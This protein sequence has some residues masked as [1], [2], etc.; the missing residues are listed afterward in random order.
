MFTTPK[1]AIKLDLY[2][3]RLQDF[4]LVS[5]LNCLYL[6]ICMYMYTTELTESAQVD[7][8]KLKSTEIVSEE[9]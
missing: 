8:Q 7:E 5:W 4:A 6:Y 1:S 3:R 9:N 2:L